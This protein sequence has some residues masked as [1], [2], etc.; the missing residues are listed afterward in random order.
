MNK[1][2]NENN[3]IGKI[4]EISGLEEKVNKVTAKDRFKNKLIE[5]GIYNEYLDRIRAGIRKAVIIDWLIRVEGLDGYS[6]RVLSDLI[7]NTIKDDVGKVEIAGNRSLINTTTKEIIEDINELKEL[8]DLY[9]LQR[10]RIDID[11]NTEKKINKLFKTTGYEIYLATKIL[12]EILRVKMEL[13]V[14]KRSPLSVDLQGGN[15]NI[16]QNGIVISDEARRKIIGILNDIRKLGIEN[17]KSK[18]EIIKAITDKIE[19][20]NDDSNAKQ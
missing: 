4:K 3:V 13:G 17:Y 10:E 16:M 7:D 2:N 20:F 1:D 5:M 12:S 9:K 11:Y 8:N 6:R 14:L 19:K 15:V 18:D